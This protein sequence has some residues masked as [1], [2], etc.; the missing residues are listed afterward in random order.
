MQTWGDLPGLRLV[1]RQASAGA[2]KLFL[3]LLSARQIGLEELTLTEPARTELD[4]A[5]ALLEGK[6][7]VAFG[8]A[9]VAATHRLQFVPVLEERFD[10]LVDRR[11]WFE[12]ALQSFWQFC[13]SKPFRARAS[14]LSGYDISNQGTVH[15]NGA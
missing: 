12:P 3:D 1:P 11:A 4:A 8:L 13:A 5:L 7:D 9:S 2:Q 10:L 14:E 6:A 15:F